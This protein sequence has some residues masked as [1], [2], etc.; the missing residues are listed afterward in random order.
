MGARR[1]E[2]DAG[3]IRTGR[4]AR[5]RELAGLLG[6]QIR[7]PRVSTVRRPSGFFPVAD[8]GRQS[9]GVLSERCPRRKAAAG[10]DVTLDV[11]DGMW[12]VWQATPGIPESREAVDAIAA[13]FR[14]HVTR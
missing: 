8:P 12:H 5:T 13:F 9:R 4:L 7:E 14:Q 2:N 1:N 3:R 10:V 6:G 11:W